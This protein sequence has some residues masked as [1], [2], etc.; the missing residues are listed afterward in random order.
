MAGAV[1][2][3]PMLRAQV[4]AEEWQARVEL[5]AVFRLV[6][7]DGWADLAMAHASARIPGKKNEFLF[8]P[9]ELTF[10]EITASSLQKIDADGN[11]MMP[12]PYA[13][14]KFAYALQMPTYRRHP[15]ANCII[16]LHSHAGTAVSMQKDGLLPSSQY[17]LWLGP[18]SY[19]HYEGHVATQQEGDRLAEAFGDSKLLMMRCH[20]TMNWGETIAQAYILA[21]LLTRACEK[22]VMALAGQ[23]ELYR[24]EP[25]VIA[26]TPTQARSITAPDGPFGLQNWKAA[27]R[28]LD[29]ESPGYDT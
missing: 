12:S 26:R 3:V 19:M 1:S 27:L 2:K 9:T 16:H 11:L 13:P 21:W 6:A 20:G 5:A 17:A 7:L 8:L 14:H 28:R 29:R 22:Q 18:I 25:D 24:P 15:Q 23:T 10:D 4:S